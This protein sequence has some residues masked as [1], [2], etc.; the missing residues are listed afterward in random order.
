MRGA[1]QGRILV[2]SFYPQA[3]M[4]LSRAC[5]WWPFV[6]GLLLVC[7]CGGGADRASVS[8]T[9]TLDQRPVEA[10]SISFVPIEGTQSPSAGAVITNGQYDIPRDKGPMVG[11]FRVEIHAPHKT[12]KK[13]PVGSPAPPGTLADEVI[14]AVPATY[15]TRSTLRC[16][17]KAGSNTLNFD[18]ARKKS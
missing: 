18:L 17:V 6:G 8:G 16:E 5:C 14:D 15:N 13:V 12:G 11:V 10:G 1:P 2:R 7:G 3:G 4:T 9:V